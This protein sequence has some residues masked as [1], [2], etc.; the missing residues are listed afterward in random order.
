MPDT[1]SLIEALQAGPGC[2]EL[3]DRVLVAFGWRKLKTR[4][5]IFWREPDGQQPHE[6]PSPTQRVDDALAL[7]RQTFP[8]HCTDYTLEKAGTAFYF[9]F[10][11]AESGPA[12][13]ECAAI[14]IAVLKANQPENPASAQTQ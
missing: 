6:L 14:N 11:L 12:N 1:D 8:D 10:A 7:W 4:L 9:S 2:R 13:D 5:G 3:D